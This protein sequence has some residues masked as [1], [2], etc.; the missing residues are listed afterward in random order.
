MGPIHYVM[1]CPFSISNG[2]LVEVELCLPNTTFEGY[3]AKLILLHAHNGV[4]CFFVDPGKR[5]CQPKLSPMHQFTDV[6]LIV[7]TI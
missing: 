5:A 4:L 3:V 1:D 2:A 6:H 7:T